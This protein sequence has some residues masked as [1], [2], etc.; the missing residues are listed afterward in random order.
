MM[1]R[2]PVWE[3]VFLVFSLNLGEKIASISRSMQQGK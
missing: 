2:H 1:T 3:L